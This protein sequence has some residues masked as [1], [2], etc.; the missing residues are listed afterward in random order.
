MSAGRIWFSIA[1]TIAS[2][3][4]IWLLF[5]IVTLIST[6][7]VGVKAH[8]NTAQM[9]WEVDSLDSAGPAATAG[10]LVG[11]RLVRIDDVTL[12]PLDLA[13]DPMA[14]GYWPKEYWQR[15]KLIFNTIRIGHPVRT[16][17]LRN[18]ANR[19]ITLIPGKMPVWRQWRLVP[20]TLVIVFS[21]GLGLLVWRKQNNVCG[22]LSAVNGIAVAGGLVSALLVQH[23]WSIDV[24]LLQS[25][26]QA[27]HS[28]SFV[29]FTLFAHIGL[30]FPRPLPILHRLPML[31]YAIYLVAGTAVL[32]DLSHKLPDTSAMATHATVCLGFLI[33]GSLALL[34]N[35]FKLRDPIEKL[36]VRGLVFA[37]C[38]GYSYVAAAALY[39][40]A[41]HGDPFWHFIAVFGSSVLAQGAFALAIARY[42]ILKLDRLIDNTVLFFVLIAVFY[43]LDL[44]VTGIIG[45]MAP[46]WMRWRLSASLLL[47]GLISLY[48]PIRSR[49]ITF[50][51]RKLRG[52]DY[53]AE[54]IV[55]RFLAGDMAASDERNI[56]SGLY[57]TLNDTFYPHGIAIYLRNKKNSFSLFQGS[58]DNVGTEHWEYLLRDPGKPLQLAET[59]QAISHP[60]SAGLLAP[61]QHGRQLMGYVVLQNKRSDKIY[62]EQDANLTQTLCSQTAMVLYYQ[63]HLR[64]KELRC[65]NLEQ[66]RE[67]LAREIHDGVGASLTTI[68]RLSQANELLMDKSLVSINIVD[69]IKQ[70]A[71]AGMHS[72]RVNLWSLDEEN[73]RLADVI[74]YLERQVITP[75]LRRARIEVQ[76]HNDA[77]IGEIE[78]SFRQRTAVVRCVQEWVQN[79]LKHANCSAVIFRIKQQNG[80]LELSI[81]DNG[82][83]F[84]VSTIPRG[85]YGMNNL[86]KRLADVGG[87]IEWFSRPGHG[88]KSIL[89][90][91]CLSESNTMETAGNAQ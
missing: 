26:T 67:V 33:A 81:E 48:I 1:L 62:T 82:V 76:L 39:V 23:E 35:F 8:W 18:G 6:P 69:A 55:R 41:W 7:Y 22:L 79:I 77:K 50:I 64:K 85:H 47:F 90:L 52:A 21:L 61:I 29:I 28:L 72:I 57:E 25:Y 60:Y 63:E 13:Q 73:N 43:V 84:L 10:L 80:F 44:A 66:E 91:P 9:H 83:G 31:P 51:K 54:N 20:L 42:K 40:S 86:R 37:L 12:T 45:W 89:S 19:T 11:D 53:N 71:L 2:L 14:F 4:G 58:E 15:K 17:I 68:M 65:V 24:E 16:Q 74:D 59:T 3:C 78:L 36:Q 88:T 87:Q 34:M 75:G 30:V 46:E 5:S 38:I 49:V 56:V 70:S 32:L 27:A